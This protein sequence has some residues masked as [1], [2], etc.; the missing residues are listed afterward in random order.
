VNVDLFEAAF[1]QMGKSC[2]PDVAFR[3]SRLGTSDA[4]HEYFIGSLPEPKQFYLGYG[5]WA[6]TY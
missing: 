1:Q 3:L 4:I 5:V 2:K 6:A